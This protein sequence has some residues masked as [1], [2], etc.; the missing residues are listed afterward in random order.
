MLQKKSSLTLSAAVITVLASSSYATLATDLAPPTETLRKGVGLPEKKRPSAHDS[1]IKNP[2]KTAAEEAAEKKRAERDAEL[3][4]I[5]QA[6][7]ETEVKSAEPEKKPAE[8][9]ELAP[10]PKKETS[11]PAP[12]PAEKPASKPRRTIQEQIQINM[13]EKLLR[14]QQMNKGK[15]DVKPVEKSTTLSDKKIRQT[16]LIQQ[17][18]DEQKMIDEQAQE[19]AA[20]KTPPPP[21]QPAT[22]PAAPPAP[23]PKPAPTTASPKPTGAS[24]G[25]TEEGKPAAQP[26]TNKATLPQS[27][28]G[29][30]PPPAPPLPPRNPV[31]P[32]PST[33]PNVETSQA[34][35]KRAGL[36]NDLNTN[37]PQARLKKVDKNT[38]HKS[39]G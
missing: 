23:L 19:A 7:R 13:Q 21:A 33:P 9:P 28:D 5:R 34:Q 6:K 36:L 30:P 17:M 16:P 1:W 14:R 27:S 39:S 2:Q 15:A 32:T 3:E 20:T 37:A 29:I 11:S 35:S 24:R 25:I 12:V 22:P 38:P 26:S 4:A 8:A 10:S 18:I 31:I